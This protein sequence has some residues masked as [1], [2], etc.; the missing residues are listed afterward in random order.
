MNLAGVHDCPC[1]R[2]PFHDVTSAFVE[3]DAEDET[4][5]RPSSN[6]LRYQTS[7]TDI[8]D[9]YQSDDNYS[10]DAYNNSNVENIPPPPPPC[11][12][13]PPPSLPL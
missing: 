3:S 5:P 12:I 11:H 8:F 13:Q 10:I 2:K 1:S 6:H 9:D 7:T 4:V